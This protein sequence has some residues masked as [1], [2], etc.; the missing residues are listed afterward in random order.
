MK[1]TTTTALFLSS[2]ACTASTTSVVAWTPL[3]SGSSSSSSPQSEANAEKYKKESQRSDKLSKKQFLDQYKRPSYIGVRTS[4][5]SKDASQ[6]TMVL[7][8][9]LDILLKDGKVVKSYES[10]ASKKTGEISDDYA[11]PIY[12]FVN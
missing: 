11:K 12:V 7:Q 2:L 10:K 1:T 4:K 9:E 5:D 6:S 8:S 3:S